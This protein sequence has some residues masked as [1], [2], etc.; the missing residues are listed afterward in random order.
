M[1]KITLF[2]GDE[3]SFV[4]K[5]GFTCLRSRSSRLRSFQDQTVNVFQSSSQEVSLQPKAIFVAIFTRMSFSWRLTTIETQTLTIW[6]WN[7]L[8][9]VYDLTIC[10]TKLNLYQGSQIFLINDLDVDQMTLIFNF[11]PD[12]AMMPY[13][14]KMKFLYQLVDNL[15]H[16]NFIIENCLK[17]H[18]LCFTNNF[19]QFQPLATIKVNGKGWNSKNERYSNGNLS[20]ATQHTTE[21]S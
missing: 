16:I 12:S 5:L 11:D 7:D 13:H 15:Y 19:L 18:F 9:L 21:A 17:L 6:P 8:D 3:R 20:L 4:L 10:K 2:H 1:L 14:T